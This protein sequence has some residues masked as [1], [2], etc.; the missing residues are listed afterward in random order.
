MELTAL[1]LAIHD[2]LD[3]VAVSH[4]FGGA[5]AL[6]YY[7]EPRGTVDVDVNVF[8]PP[9]QLAAVDDAFKPLGYRRGDENSG[10]PIAGVR[11]TNPDL[12]F[13]VD[14]FPTLDPAYANAEGRVTLR[15][16]GSG[17]PRIPVLSADDLTVFKLSFGRPKD[18]VDIG[19]MAAAV[20]L[21]FEYIAS[22]LLALRGSTMHPRL[23]R[24]QELLPRSEPTG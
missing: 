14:A 13:P 7:A 11:Y 15:A 6:A 12:P 21:D 24:F 10:P 16:F 4:A 8:L 1:V 20:P 2:R 5:L 9:E 23:S 18:W 19:E 17:G 22:Q 3:A